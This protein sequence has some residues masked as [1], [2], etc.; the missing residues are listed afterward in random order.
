VCVEG[1]QPAP[2]VLSHRRTAS[3]PPPPPS[4][5][6]PTHNKQVVVKAQ[7]LAGGRGLGKFTNGLAGGVHIVPA[8]DA[9]ALAARML[10]GTL[11]T[12]QTGPAGKPVNTLL[13][14]RKMDLARE[15]Y[16]AILLDR[17]AAGPV[18]VACSEGERWNEEREVFLEGRAPRTPRAR[19]ARHL[20]AILGA[21]R[22]C[23][24]GM[25]AAIARGGGGG[26]RRQ[27]SLTHT[28]LHP[29]HQLKKIHAARPS[30]T[31]RPPTRT[32]SSKCRSTRASA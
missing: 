24:V 10:G 13:V 28:P 20:A 14:A 8:A 3:P 2:A 31:W 5:N 19:L 12:K 27:L 9:P 26:S 16:L 32:R 29:H 4:T 7:V 17:K 6:R 22:A 25:D 18:V 1:R 21:R 15:M 30:R 23:F 11:V